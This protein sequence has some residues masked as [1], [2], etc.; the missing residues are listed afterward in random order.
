MNL[1]REEFHKLK[2]LDVFKGK[3]VSNSMEPVINVG[4]EIIVIVDDLN[5]KRFDII[6]FYFE[7][8]LVCHF[9]WRLN[10]IIHPMVLQ[11]RNMLGG[12]DWPIS[13]DDYFGKVVS[14]KLSF[15]QKLKLLF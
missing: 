8:K 3:I 10:K 13:L 7:N 1:S 9:L 6:V 5:L 12:Y 11:T 2:E 15:W 4:D 14:H